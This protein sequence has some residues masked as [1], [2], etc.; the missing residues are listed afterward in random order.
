[1]IVANTAHANPWRPAHI[2]DECVS[3]VPVFGR[4]EIV[5][6][7]EVIAPCNKNANSN[8]IPY[9]N[10]DVM[11]VIFSHVNGKSLARCEQVCKLWKE[12]VQKLS[13]VK[14]PFHSVNY[15]TAV[16]I[17]LNAYCMPTSKVIMVN[18][19]AMLLIWKVVPYE[20]WLTT[21]FV[22]LGL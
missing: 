4:E 1:V 16:E 7:F 21:C 5:S 9:L 22:W 15:K 2:F 19:C 13:Q 14:D 10:P 3:L 6:M 20:M 18:K 12:L 11:E 8:M 17:S